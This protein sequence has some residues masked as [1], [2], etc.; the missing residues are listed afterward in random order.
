MVGVLQKRRNTSL[1]RKYILDKKSIIGILIL[2]FASTQF[3]FGQKLS[4]IVALDSAK[5]EYKFGRI[6]K[7][8]QFL[9]DAEQIKAS[10]Q[11]L[12]EIYLYKARIYSMQLNSSEAERCTY[13]LLVIRPF[14]EFANDEFVEITRA[15]ANA[16]ISPYFSFGT[17]YGLNNPSVNSSNESSLISSSEITTISNSSVNLGDSYG[18]NAEFYLRRRWSI[19]TEFNLT[20]LNF[21]RSTSVEGLAT[22]ELYFHFKYIQLPI[23]MRFDILP[24]LFYSKKNPI[25]ISVG[26]GAYGNKLNSAEAFSGGVDDYYYGINAIN[27]NNYF[28]SFTYGAWADASFA[29]RKNRIKFSL[30]LRYYKDFNLANNS[31]AKYS[32][33]TGDDIIFENYQIIDDI[34]FSNIT[35]NFGLNY[36]LRYKIFDDIIKKKSNDD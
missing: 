35:L 17:F 4:S 20:Q 32:I 24:I 22:S 33:G 6:E 27:V 19:Y 16:K 10:R 13:S 18:I 9:N 26:A 2:I 8:M 25:N 15:A 7:A 23:G 5:I 28:N 30:K 34:Y 3:T 31:Y 1:S 36:Y 29:Y 21:T 14:T 11:V 12:A